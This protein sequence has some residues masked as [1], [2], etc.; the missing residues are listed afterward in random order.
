MFNKIYKKV[1]KSAK[2]GAFFIAFNFFE[3][4]AKNLHKI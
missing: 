3:K 1:L 4:N 2:N